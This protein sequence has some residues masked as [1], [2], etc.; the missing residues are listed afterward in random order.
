MTHQKKVG[1]DRFG[2]SDGRLTGTQWW[3]VREGT[4]WW[5]VRDGVT[6]I[7]SEAGIINKIYNNT[8]NYEIIFF[9]NT[10]IYYI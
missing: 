1:L 9:Y 6:V 4:Q 3:H 5:H 7:A 2:R 10:R 8:Q